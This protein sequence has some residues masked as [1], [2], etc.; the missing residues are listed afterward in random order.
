MLRS[1]ARIDALNGLKFCEQF[2][3][4]TIEQNKISLNLILSI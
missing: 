3:P 1:H 2:K 4:L